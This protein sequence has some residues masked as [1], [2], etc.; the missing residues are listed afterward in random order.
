MKLDG[1][2]ALRGH[3]PWN[4][5]HCADAKLYAQKTFAS[6]QFKSNTT[7]SEI[8][9]TAQ[10]TVAFCRDILMTLR[11]PPLILRWPLGLSSH[12]GC[13]PTMP[14]R[15]FNFTCIFLWV[16]AEAGV[17]FE[18]SPTDV[19]CSL[20]RCSELWWLRADGCPSHV[21]TRICFVTAHVVLMMVTSAHTGL[22]LASQSLNS[23][24]R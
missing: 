3:K 9:K 13:L 19:P 5:S 20:V 10:T 4:E 14:H 6:V 15:R 23:E 11:E 21:I 2:R 16:S 8:P 22:F 12:E 18:Q 17:C 7:L 1:A 24:E